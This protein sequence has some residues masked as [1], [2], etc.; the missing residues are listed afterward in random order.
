MGRIYWY[1]EIRT[2]PNPA[3]GKII[4]HVP[5]TKEEDVEKAVEA[6]KAGIQ[7]MV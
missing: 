2:V 5:L 1:R 7:N 6:A 3:T 4:T